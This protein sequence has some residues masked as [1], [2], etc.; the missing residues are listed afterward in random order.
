MGK[1]FYQNFSK[2]K[3]V[4]ETAS[5]ILKLDLKKI[6]FEDEKSQLVQTYITQPSI[7]TVS[8]MIVN[9]IIDHLPTSSFTSGHSLGE[10]TA[11]AFSKVFNFQTGL[12]LVKFRGEFMDECC[13][14]QSG[15][16]AAVLGLDYN[17]V[18]NICE[19]VSNQ[20]KEVCQAVNLN[21]PT[22]TVIA[23][24]TKALELARE[25]FKELKAKFIPLKTSGAFHS[26][27]MTK[28]SLKMKEVIENEKFYDA[29]IPVITNYDAK[30]TTKSE[31]FKQKLI[32]QINNPVH[33]Y[34]SIYLM[35]ENG[36]DVFIEIG[37]GNVL[38]NLVTKIVPNSQ[39]YSISKIEDLKIF[40]KFI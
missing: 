2:S 35:K 29:E 38:S 21:T 13:R 27:L 14:N 11:L 33:W 3:E 37:P 19:K 4:L 1:D 23:G 16:M 17:Q 20:S 7:Y 24:T 34:E 12:R 6:I 31:D 18:K 28:A 30:I 39:A 22:Q 25:R 5:E 9:A 32:Y 8:W 36:V 40:E 10:Y 15:G 26:S